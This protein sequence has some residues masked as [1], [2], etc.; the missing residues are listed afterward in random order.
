MTEERKGNVAAGRG[1]MAR[2]TGRAIVEKFHGDYKSYEEAIRAEGKPYEVIKGKNKVLYQ[3]INQIFTFLCGGSGT[4]FSNANAR[5]GIGSSTVAADPTQTGLQAEVVVDDAETVWTPSANVTAALDAADYKV[6][7]NSVKL[8]VAD[9]FATGL[10]AYHDRA[11]IDLSS[12][13]YI[14]M[15]IKSSLARVAGDL[16]LLLDDTA[17]SIS[18]L[19]SIDI[20][21]LS[22]GVWTELTLELANPSLLTAVIS[23]GLKAVVDPGISDI[24]VDD[25]KAVS[26]WYKGMDAGYPIYGTDQKATFKATFSGTEG[27]IPWKEWTVDN[28]LADSPI[29]LVRGVQDFG[30]KIAGATRTLTGEYTITPA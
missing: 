20:P 21:A 17:G 12:Y 3:G 13:K 2:I 6:G 8:S 5:M 27:N 18:P 24:W 4:V 23:V 15:W 16:Q 28:G 25:V 11:A 30:T 9:A 10:V 14:R 26:T 19:E 1:G 29:N 22:P 7:S